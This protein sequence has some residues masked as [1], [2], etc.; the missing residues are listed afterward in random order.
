[1]SPKG[2]AGNSTGWDGQ[3]AGGTSNVEVM[4]RASELGLTDEVQPA[5]GRGS[6]REGCVR[7]LGGLQLKVTE[8]PNQR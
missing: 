7:N 6:G 3:L 1:M 8:D 5:R 4:E 2:S